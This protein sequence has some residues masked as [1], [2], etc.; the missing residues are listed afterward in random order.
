LT[1]KSPTDLDLFTR[2]YN[3]ELGL[4]WEKLWHN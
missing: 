4:Y 3:G 2:Y 1:F